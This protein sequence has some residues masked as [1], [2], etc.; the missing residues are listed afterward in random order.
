MRG[1]DRYNGNMVDVIQ[2]F[3]PIVYTQE[4]RD[5]NDSDYRT[6][7]GGYH[8]DSHLGLPSQAWDGKDKWHA[9]AVGFFKTV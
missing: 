1:K 5:G 9:T 8:V 2:C 7:A 4:L 3:P 6:A